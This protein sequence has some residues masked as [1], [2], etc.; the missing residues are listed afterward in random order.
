MCYSILYYMFCG[1]V[2][3]LVYTEHLPPNLW[4][5][6]LAYCLLASLPPWYGL[7][8]A[9]FPVIIYFFLGTSRHISVGKDG[10][11]L[12][13]DPHTNPHAHHVSALLRIYVCR[14]LYRCISGSEYNGGVGCDPS[15][16]GWRSPSQ[17]YRL[18]R[19]HQ[20]WA[21]GH[22]GSICYL[23]HGDYPGQTHKHMNIPH[24]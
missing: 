17:H 19:A 16:A 11:H 7:Y 21:E 4:L 24:W 8:T 2:W 13:A 12:H 3:R 20:G 23:P 10:N 5:P 9:F 22:G 1:S 14:S 6:G 18:W 15:S